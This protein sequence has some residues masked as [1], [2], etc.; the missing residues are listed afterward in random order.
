MSLKESSARDKQ[1]IGYENCD[2]TYQQII[3]LQR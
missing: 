3:D 2:W 1:K